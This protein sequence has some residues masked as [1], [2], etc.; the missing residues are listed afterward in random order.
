LN[1]EWPKETW[2]RNRLGYVRER[3]P[4]LSLKT[5]RKFSHQEHA[6]A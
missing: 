2:F 1:W 6:N 5:L 4:V 3:E